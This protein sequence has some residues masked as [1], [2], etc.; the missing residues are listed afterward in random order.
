MVVENLKIYVPQALEVLTLVGGIFVV[1]VVLV[2][3]YGLL[4]GKKSL[5]HRINGLLRHHYLL[6]GLIVSL[7]A[8]LGSLFY[9]NIMQFNPCG[10]CWWQRIFMYPQVVLFAVALWKRDIKIARYVL[11]LSM[12][13]GAIAAYHYAL[14]IGAVSS[15][16]PCSA[17]GY[18]ASC[19]ELFFVAYGYITIPMMALTAFLMLIIFGFSSRRRTDA[20]EYR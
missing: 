17:V 6:F 10:L 12:I 18:S 15:S 14:Q 3:L 7:I 11:P 1:A 8:T 2:Y 16:L 20:I 19:T 13:G 9:S 5:I 4:S